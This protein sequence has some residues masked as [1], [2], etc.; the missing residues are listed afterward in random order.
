MSD[1]RIHQRRSSA[2][3]KPSE[4][5][6]WPEAKA[7]ERA[8]SAPIVD[9]AG[10]AS[11]DREREERR[12]SWKVRAPLEGAARDAASGSVNSLRASPAPLPP[13]WWGGAGSTTWP[14]LWR[15]RG[16]RCSRR[17]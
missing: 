16:T 17:C 15:D 6:E 4:T 7:C 13:R 8:Q 5:P 2:Q 12:R 14:T 1:V 3:L 9:S 10:A 11:L